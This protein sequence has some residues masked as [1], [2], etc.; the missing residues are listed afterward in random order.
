MKWPQRL[1]LARHA[2]SAFN[3]LRPQ[4]A[5]TPLYQEFLASFGAQWD[6]DRTRTLAGQVQATFALA[7]RRP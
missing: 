5:A 4:K 1:T 7:G 6:S 3:L 2:P